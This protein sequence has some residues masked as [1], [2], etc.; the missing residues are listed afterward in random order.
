[1]AIEEVQHVLDQPDMHTQRGFR[2]RVILEVLYTSA[3]RRAEISHLLIDD[4][5]IAQGYLTVRKGKNGKDR[6][7]PLG[8]TACALLETYLA[9]VRADWLGAER[10]RSLFLNQYGDGMGVESI[11][12]VVKKY[13]ALA[14]LTKP[15]S[16]HS[17]RHTCA[18]H[19]MRNGAPIRH[20]Q[21]ML[22]HSSID[23]TQIYTR[24]TINDLRDAHHRFHPREQQQAGD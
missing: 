7:V 8:A 9:G 19:M 22:G 12:R 3:I 15:V 1:M 4:V 5:D 18:T 6:V 17:F 10:N 20:L 23:S 11:W 13:S 14:G 24:V 16:T 21:E 2:D